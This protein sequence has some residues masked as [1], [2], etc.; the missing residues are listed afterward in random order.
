MIRPVSAK[1]AAL[2]GLAAVWGFDALAQSPPQG[3]PRWLP[4]INQEIAPEPQ[5]GTPQPRRGKQSVQLRF[6]VAAQDLPGLLSQPLSTACALGRFN[7]REYDRYFIAVPRPNAPPLRLGFAGGRA[8][9]LS[10]PDRAALE[11]QY[12][13]FDKDRTSECRVYAAQIPQ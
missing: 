7:Q 3:D 8:G 10:D 1:L 4:L 6:D 5:L 11:T 12:Y 2:L 9:N 13:L